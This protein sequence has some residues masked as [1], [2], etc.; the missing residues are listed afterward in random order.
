MQSIPSLYNLII[1]HSNP[2]KWAIF[3]MFQDEET[4]AYR[5]WKLNNVPE[6]SH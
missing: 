1:P 5:T 4:K 2:L 6:D 3:L